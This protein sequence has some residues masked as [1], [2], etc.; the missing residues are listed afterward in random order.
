MTSPSLSPFREEAIPGLAAAE[1]QRDKRKE[2][3]KKK[4]KEK[5]KEKKVRTC[6]G[7]FRALFG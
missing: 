1:A 7:V 4:E 5:E 3:E 6:S 2:E